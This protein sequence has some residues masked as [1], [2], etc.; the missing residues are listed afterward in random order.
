[1]RRTQNPDYQNS[2]SALMLALA[3]EVRKL[4]RDEEEHES[5]EEAR[6]RGYRDAEEKYKSDILREISCAARKGVT[7]IFLPVATR[8]INSELT[9]YHRGLIQRYQELARADHYGCSVFFS[10]VCTQSS[11]LMEYKRVW[12]LNI[13]WHFE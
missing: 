6:A 3:N 11:P 5:K 2:P 13:W 1:M 10:R 4:T 7:R 12:I 9:E 8:P